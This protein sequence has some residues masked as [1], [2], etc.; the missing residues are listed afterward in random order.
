M[1]FAR[2]LA[3]LSRASLAALMLVLLPAAAHA[4]AFGNINTPALV[5]LAAAGAGTTDSADQTNYYDKGVA[6]GINI[7]AKSG[8]IAVTVAITSRRRPRRL[9]AA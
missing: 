7:S 2:S 3:D 1:T 4:Q 9:R 5:T 8:T 6:L